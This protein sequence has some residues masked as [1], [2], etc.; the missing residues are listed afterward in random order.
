ML[1]QLDEWIIKVLSKPG[2]LMEWCSQWR[3]VKIP[4]KSN[5]TGLFRYCQIL[6][7]SSWLFEKI[8]IN[9]G[10]VR[11]IVQKPHCTKYQRKLTLDSTYQKVF[12]TVNIVCGFREN[13]H[14]TKF[15][16]LYVCAP[17]GCS[18]RWGDVSETLKFLP[19]RYSAASR[20]H[21]SYKICGYG[22][23]RTYICSVEFPTHST[24]R[25]LPS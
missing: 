12:D 4:A 17:V 9:V 10:S 6:F 5:H 23:H 11:N 8:I 20:R 15:K 21:R 7:S 2:K 19:F 3:Q 22:S 13:Y 14:W 1:K 24:Y 18:P 16:L 25:L